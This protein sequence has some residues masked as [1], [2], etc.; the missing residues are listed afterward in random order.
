[1]AEDPNYDFTNAPDKNNSEGRQ[2]TLGNRTF[3]T[4][5]HHA[6]STEAFKNSPFPQREVR[7]LATGPQGKEVK[8][9]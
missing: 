5:N 8:V 6:L 2:F 1:M 3:T 9:V 7:Y 4:Q